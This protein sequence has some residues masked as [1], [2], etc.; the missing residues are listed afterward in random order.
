MGRPAFPVGARRTGGRTANLKAAASSFVHEYAA[1]DVLKL[2]KHLMRGS[3]LVRETAIEL[4]RLMLHSERYCKEKQTRI[5]AVKVIVAA[6]PRTL[7]E[8]RYLLNKQSSRH[9]YEVH[10]TLFCYLDLNELPRG[11]TGRSRILSLLKKYLMSA[12]S[13]RGS[14][15]WMCG[16]LLGDHW[17]TRRAI[18]ALCDVAANAEHAVARDSAVH[19][20]AHALDRVSPSQN[21]R[22]RK[23]LKSLA[24]ADTSGRVRLSS[25]NT[26][27]GRGR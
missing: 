15:A 10:F 3:P 22:I 17:G 12:S 6:L 20:L 27:N 5:A 18:D 8:M 25:R 4:A 13:D 26:L 14:A 2:R 7:H 23:L 21:K 9:S 16:D 24:A 11:E 1:M 19:G